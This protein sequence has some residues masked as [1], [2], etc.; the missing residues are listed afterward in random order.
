[1]RA[2]LHAEMSLRIRLVEDDVARLH[3][4]LAP[5]GH[6]IARVH[7]EV[8]DDLLHAARIGA[9]PAEWLRGQRNEVHVRAEDALEHL[10][11]AREHVVQ[12]EHLRR[13]HLLAAEHEQLP[14]EIGGALPGLPDLLDVVAHRLAGLHVASSMSP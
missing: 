11:H 7:D 1:V 9:H 3:R 12:V 4:E 6:G 10:V 13:E 2:G 8:H 5:R 14:R